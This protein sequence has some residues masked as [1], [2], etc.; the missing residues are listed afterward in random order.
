METTIPT[1]H[2]AFWEALRATQD[3]RPRSSSKAG[4]SRWTPDEIRACL[5]SWAAT[6]GRPPKSSELRAAC[7]LPD[8]HSVTVFWPTMQMLYTEL[9]WPYRSYDRTTVDHG[10]P[11]R[12]RRKG[13]KGVSNCICLRCDQPFVSDDPRQERICIACKNTEEFRESG[14]WMNGA[15]VNRAEDWDD[16]WQESPE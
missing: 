15:F 16:V 6:E 1:P 13:R 10:R 8:Y 11:R 12:E 2:E 7:Q 4:K 5:Q 3:L 14:A 9:G